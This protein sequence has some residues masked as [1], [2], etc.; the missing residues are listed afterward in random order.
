MLKNRHVKLKLMIKNFSKVL[1]NSSKILVVAV[2]TAFIMSSTTKKISDE[3]K[4][5]IQVENELFSQLRQVDIE[6]K[7]HYTPALKK[8]L[9]SHKITA[10]QLYLEMV[11][12]K[13]KAET[14]SEKCCVEIG[15]NGRKRY[16]RSYYTKV[17]EI[18]EKLTSAIDSKFGLTREIRQVF[19]NNY[20]MCYSGK[21]DKYCKE[22]KCV[23][24]KGNYW[25]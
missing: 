3:Q 21:T 9:T 16:L 15:S 11:N 13:Y 5:I 14:E 24:E 4:L 8:I 7:H 2:G 22:G 23:L 19:K 18:E 12:I 6:G 25:N 20:C 17:R 1:I 10:Y